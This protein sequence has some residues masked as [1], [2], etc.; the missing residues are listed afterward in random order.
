MT[1]I[2]NLG[3]VAEA[4]IDGPSLTASIGFKTIIVAVAKSQLVPFE[5][6][7]HN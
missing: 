2:I 5:P 6:T 7:S 4:A 1:F 3:V